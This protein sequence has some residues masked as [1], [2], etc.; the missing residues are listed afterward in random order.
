MLWTQS[1]G[2]AQAKLE[3]YK[4]SALASRGFQAHVSTPMG[5]IFLNRSSKTENVKE[6]IEKLDF[7]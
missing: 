2:V 5:Y 3:G 7:K 1:L 6:S 4:N